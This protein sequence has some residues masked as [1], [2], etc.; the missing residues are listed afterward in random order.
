MSNLEISM[1]LHFAAIC[2]PYRGFGENSSA[3]F[4]ALNRLSNRALIRLT[5]ADEKRQGSPGYDWVAT[6]RGYA[7]VE[8]LKQVQA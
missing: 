6:E 3:Y 2:E 4:N 8:A 5:T 1:M 7:Y